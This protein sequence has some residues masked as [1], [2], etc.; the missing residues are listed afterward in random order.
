MRLIRSMT[1]VRFITVDSNAAVRTLDG[2]GVIVGNGTL[3]VQ[4]S[5]SPLSGLYA[6]HTPSLLPQQ[7]C[8]RLGGRTYIKSRAYIDFR[9]GGF[10][11]LGDFLSINR[12]SNQLEITLS[13]GR[14]SPDVLQSVPHPQ[15]PPDTNLAGSGCSD[16]LLSLDF[17]RLVRRFFLIFFSFSIAGGYCL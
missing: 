7:L 5:A 4:C 15:R 1:S 9:T 6:G 10:G 3:L 12:R 17:F 11:G 13:D 2:V 16:H 8:T 14:S